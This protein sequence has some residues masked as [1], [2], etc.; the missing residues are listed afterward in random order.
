[1]KDNIDFANSGH[2]CYVLNHQKELCFTWTSNKFEK[3]KED[4]LEK[5][6]IFLD[7]DG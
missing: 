2:Q 1:M 6:L 4:F 3:S 5:G 7:K